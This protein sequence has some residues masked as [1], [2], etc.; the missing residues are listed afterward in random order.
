MTASQFSDLVLLDS[1]NPEADILGGT[2]RTHNWDISRQIVAAV[3]VPVFLA[4]GLTPVN[5]AAAMEQVQPAGVDVCS[6]VRVDGVLDEGKLKR[7]VEA[8]KGE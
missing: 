8:V 5:V 1:G 2:G 4:G 7:F 3:D 6:G